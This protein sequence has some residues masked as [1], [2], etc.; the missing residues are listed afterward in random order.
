M[1]ESEHGFIEVPV[2]VV[3]LDCN[4]RPIQS[5]L[6]QRPKI[7]DGLSVDLTTNILLDVVDGFVNKALCIE[8]NISQP[9]IAI[10]GRS[11]A[12]TVKDGLL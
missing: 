11:K 6:E 8:S 4:V 9:S 3:W 2:H 1:V 7:L 5:P 12:Y 10:D